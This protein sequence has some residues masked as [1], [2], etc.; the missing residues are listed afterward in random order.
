MSSVVFAGAIVGQLCMG[1]AGDVFGR[2]RALILTNLFTALGALCSALA[3]WGTSS[4]VYLVIIVSRFVLG[5]GV[6]GK[7]PLAGTVSSEGAAGAKGGRA[8]GGASSSSSSSATS[9]K[10]AKAL[11]VA[12][13]FFWQTPGTMLPYAIGM[14][15]LAACKLT[16]AMDIPFLQASLGFRIVLGLGALP[17][18]AVVLLTWCQPDTA[19]TAFK[20]PT[21]WR[22]IRAHPQLW[23][24]LVGTGGSWLLY[25]FLY[26]GLTLNQP[27][28]IEQAFG[29]ADSAYS[30]LWQNLLAAS[31]GIPG[32]VLAIVVLPKLGA[33]ALQAY[34]FILLSVV[35]AA[36]AA[37]NFADP[38]IANSSANHSQDGPNEQGTSPWALFGTLCAVIFALN[39]GPNVSE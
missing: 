24:A 36:M 18:F 3:S 34:G 22:D 12:F 2:K 32:V 10:R 4:T 30:V 21:L 35:C 7:Y 29:T 28:I 16:H 5:V 13:G 38:Q 20:R 11:E 15:F 37:L 25:D 6:G 27:A 23:R 14:A 17:A 8:A 33:K 39:W 31:V 19:M 1:V 9:S 26:Y